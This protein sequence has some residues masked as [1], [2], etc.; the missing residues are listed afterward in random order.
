MTTAFFFTNYNKISFH[1]FCFLEE[2]LLRYQIIKLLLLPDSNY[3]RT[4]PYCFK[5]PQIIY[6]KPH[7]IRNPFSY[8][9]TEMLRASG[10]AQ[11]SSCSSQQV[12]MPSIT[13]GAV[14]VTLS[15][16]YR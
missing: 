1:S 15:M 11:C 8:T 10:G 9:F 12:Q 2:K 7:G 5:S 6:Y 16:G 14:L 13:M 4:K 3:S